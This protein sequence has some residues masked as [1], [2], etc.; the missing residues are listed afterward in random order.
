MDTPEYQEALRR[1]TSRVSDIPGM[2]GYVD[3]KH[4][5]LTVLPPIPSHVRYLFC[6]NNNLTE[7]PELPKHLKGLVCSDNQL[8]QLPNLPTSLVKLSCGNNQIMQL[9]ELPASLEFLICND[10]QIHQLP[11]LPTSLRQLYCAGNQLMQLPKLPASLLELSCTGNQLTQLPELPASLRT[12]FCERNQLTRLP[13]FPDSLVIFSM[14]NNPYIEPFQRIVQTYE[15]SRKDM[16]DKQQVRKSILAYYEILKK[17]KNVSA[18]KQ[19]LGR[20][21]N[22]PENIAS[23]M[24]SFL[25]EKPGTLNMQTTALK[26]NAGIG[27]TRRRKSRKIRK[28]RSR[29]RN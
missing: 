23:Y 6:N 13:R 27:G 14:T 1:L 28:T 20:K 16:S 3:L 10:N 21:E 18:V 17:G 24:G 25:S 5:G 15:R 4:L 22:L 12:L 2:E 7:L 8:T 29:H 9:P 26:R 19:T 11:K